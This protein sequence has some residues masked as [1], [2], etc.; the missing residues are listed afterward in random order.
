MEF[1]EKN[2]LK[3]KIFYKIPWYGPRMAQA[4]RSIFGQK[5]PLKAEEPNRRSHPRPLCTE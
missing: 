5:S 3:L 4:F 2:H 1:D